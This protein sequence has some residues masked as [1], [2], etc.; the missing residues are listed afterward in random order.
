[1][2]EAAASWPARTGRFLLKELKHVLPPTIY[3]FCAFNLIAFTSNLL[4]GHYW[5]ALSSFL[6]AT[7]L[8]LVVGKVIPIT[9]KLSLIDRFRAAP[10]IQPILYRTVFY[11]VVV[12][13]VRFVEQLIHFLFDERGF[14]AAFQAAVHAFTWQHFTAIQVWLFVCFLIYVSVTELNDRLGRGELRRLLFRS[15]LAG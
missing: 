9:D 5:F 1:V 12:A 7:T 15:R 13:V 14:A 4:I 3:F 2:S 10:L 11:T 6:V 8:A